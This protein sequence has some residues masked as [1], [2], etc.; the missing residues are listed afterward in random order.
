MKAIKIISDVPG[1]KEGIKLFSANIVEAVL[2]GENNPLEVH[3][4]I[5]A[6]EK[7]MKAVKANPDYKD[8]ILEEAE[9]YGEKTFE[10]GGVKFTV[11]NSTKYDYSKDEVWQALKEIEDKAAADRKAREAILKALKEPTAIDDIIAYPPVK[12]TSTGVRVTL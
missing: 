5:D 6:I 10:T 12:S 7:I 1:N 3:A 11:A 2:S 8:C 9:N 4:K